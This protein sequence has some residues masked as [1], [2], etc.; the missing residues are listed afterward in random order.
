MTT[1]ATQAGGPAAIDASGRPTERLPLRELVRLSIY[2]LGLSS[3]F[4]GLTTILAG[5][6]E[7]DGL[8][9]AASAG[10]TLF[11]LTIGG[12]LIAMA[13]Q[14]TIGSIS[15]YTI[16]RWGRRKPYIFI[17]TVLDLVFLAGVAFS[18]D[19]LAIAAFVAL[20]QFSSNFAQGPF[21]GY[22]P[23]LVPAP[24]VGM[25]SALVGL[26][27]ILGNVMGFVV[28]G[29]AVATD[30]FALGLIAL[31]L[32][33]F[34]TMLGVVVRVREGRAPRARA[35][36]SWLSVA[37]EAWGT[38]ILRERSFLFLVASRLAIL[39]AGAVLTNLAIFYLSRSLGMDQEASGG[40]FTVMVGLVA[41]GTLITVVPSA[42]LSDRIGRKPVIYLSCALGAI[43]LAIGGAGSGVRARARGFRA[44]RP[45]G[46]D[47]PRGR[48]GAHDGHH[49]EGRVGALHGPLER[50]HGVGGGARHRHRRIAHGHGRWWRGTARRPVGRGGPHRPRG[51]A[52][53]AGA[54][55]PAG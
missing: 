51:R 43:G 2:W 41:V 45:V 53:G 10:R 26:M 42:R 52:P 49:P 12:A 17:G 48:L 54:R 33:E 20:L 50:G 44:V 34:V 38:D 40:A 37:A 24:Q 55:R 46:R 39:M 27:Q 8:A 4:A 19:L 22:V 32:L 5:R 14:P 31:G 16:S 18:Q 30:Q 28:A 35:G 36:R 15:D 29:I 11:G 23:D 6:L 21:Q 13:V 9:D 47:V 3:I 1:S 7:Y 25:A